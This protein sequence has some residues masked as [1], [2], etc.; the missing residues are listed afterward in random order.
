MPVSWHARLTDKHH[1]GRDSNPRPGIKT[2]SSRTVRCLPRV[3]C[4]RFP[5][6]LS[7]LRFV[8]L[9]PWCPL[10]RRGRV[11]ASRATPSGCPRLRA[12]LCPSDRPALVSRDRDRQTAAVRTIA[13][14]FH[15]LPVSRRAIALATSR[16]CSSSSTPR[17]RFGALQAGPG[18]W[19][20]APCRCRR[21]EP[22]RSPRPHHHYDPAPT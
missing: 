17:L 7:D 20:A 18:N 9:L 19:E 16:L 11:R 3:A 10:E 2:H 13:D 4:V 22:R 5:V 14:V 6:G 15:P 1:S 8:G 21:A 12:T